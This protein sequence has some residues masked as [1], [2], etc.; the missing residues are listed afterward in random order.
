QIPTVKAAKESPAI[1]PPP[2]REVV[3]MSDGKP[4]AGVA[5]SPE[6]LGASSAFFLKAFERRAD[7]VDIRPLYKEDPTPPAVHQSTV[8]SSTNPPKEDAYGLERKTASRR[9]SVI[10]PV[11]EPAINCLY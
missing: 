1:S 6:R 3:L 9:K 4:S 10:F 8:G 2:M 5:P 7:R 11:R